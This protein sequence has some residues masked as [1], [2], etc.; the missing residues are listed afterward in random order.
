MALSHLSMLIHELLEKDTYIVLEQYPLN[1]LDRKSDVWVANNGKDTNHTM[2]IDIIVKNLRNGEKFK[3]HNIYW[4]EGD[5]KLAD[6]VTNN[7]G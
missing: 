2:N 5:L 3:M 7:I 6:I 4:C 1:V